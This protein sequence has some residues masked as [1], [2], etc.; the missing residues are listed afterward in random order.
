MHTDLAYVTTISPRDHMW[1]TG[2]QWYFDVGMSALDCVR[3]ALETAGVTPS[4]ILDMPSGHGR[5]A[6][7]LKAAYP[8]AHLTVCDLDPD[9]VDF[10]VATFGAEGAYSREDVRELQLPRAFDLIWCGSLFT[11]LESERWLPFLGFFERHLTQDGVLVFTTHGRQPIQWMN[12][13]SF[14]YGLQPAEQ[15]AL[16]DGYDRTGFGFVSPANQAFGLSLSSMSF[17][18]AQVERIGSLRLIGAHEAGWAGHQDVFACMHLR[19]PYRSETTL[20]APRRS[21]LR[22]RSLLGLT[23]E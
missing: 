1:A 11:H 19:R 21:R 15:Q 7:M 22:L 17:V 14:D 5:V 18:C 3:R 2:Q 16:I 13:K 12:E 6:R 20:G 9:A 8:Q 10:C 23:R 4:S